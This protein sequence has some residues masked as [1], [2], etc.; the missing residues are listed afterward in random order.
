[1]MSERWSSFLKKAKAMQILSKITKGSADYETE[2][3]MNH[4]HCVCCFTNIVHMFVRSCVC[5]RYARR[6]DG[7]NSGREV[8]VAVQGT[9][10]RFSFS[11]ED[12]F[13]SKFP[14]VEKGAICPTSVR[15]SIFGEGGRDAFVVV[16]M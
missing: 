9:R 12:Q 6:D 10:A 3:M 7:V 14:C 1:M 8:G 4:H 11:F 15:G 13:V 2:K 5:Q 16:N